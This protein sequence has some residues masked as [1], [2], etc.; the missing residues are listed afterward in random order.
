MASTS[1]EQLSASPRDEVFARLL[2]D[3]G[4]PHVAAPNLDEFSLAANPFPTVSLP[5]DRAAPDEAPQP[6][7][8]AFHRPDLR[9]EYEWLQE[10]RRRLEASTRTQF[11]LLRKTHEASLV[12][13][14]ENAQKV[15]L[16]CQEV[17]RQMKLLTSHREA[18]QKREEQ[19]AEREAGVGA[20]EHQLAEAQK[21]LTQLQQDRERI[22]AEMEAHRQ[23]L[24]PLRAEKSQ[25]EGEMATARAR[26]E[27]EL[28]EV[29]GQL[30]AHEDELA[31]RR[32]SW[33]ED[34][35]TLAAGRKHLE[36]RYLA[37]EKAEEALERRARE[38]DELEARVRRDCSEREQQLAAEQKQTQVLRTSIQSHL[39]LLKEHPELAQ[40]V[41]GW[42]KLPAHARQTLL[43][44]ISAAK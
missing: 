5:K 23:L 19:L 27:E 22:E 38:L 7:A 29:Q 33:E 31:T 11:A 36:H 21:G 6:S 41:D 8:P 18:L 28:K 3:S 30:A 43:L 10:E 9:A 40:V 4:G 12:S 42:P 13:H 20:H 14:Y 26:H 15:T 37:L 44:L 32:R 34:Q 25:L 24:E 17:N 39:A 16:H 2:Q 35:A 1:Q